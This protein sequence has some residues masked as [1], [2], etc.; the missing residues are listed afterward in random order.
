MLQS[1]GRTIQLVIMEKVSVFANINSRPSTS[2]V[3]GYVIFLF[4]FSADTPF[5]QVKISELG[6]WLARRN[7]SPPAL[8]GAISRCEYYLL[9]TF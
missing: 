9:N 5:G 6:G 7:K 4:V 3:F 1:M 2:S 8:M